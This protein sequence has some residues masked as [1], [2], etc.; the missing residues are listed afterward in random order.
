MTIYQLIVYGALGTI[1]SSIT[2]T[3]EYLQTFPVFLQKLLP[4]MPVF[5]LYLK[6]ILHLAI[7]SSALGGSYGIMFSNT[8]NLH[9]LAKNKHTFFSKFFTSLNQ[10]AIPFACVIF[11]GFMYL[12]YLFISGGDQMLLQPTAV[13]GTILAF[14]LSVIAL[15]LAK[16]KRANTK[17]NILIPIFGL[18]VCGL[19]AYQCVKTL[20]SGGISSILILFTVLLILG[21][22][23][24]FV[25]RKNNKKLAQL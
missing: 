18:F 19:M 8:W 5:A 21:Y 15:I 10:H 2:Q 13:L 16:L 4:N 3:P 6:A 12:V 11:I 1:L 7:A 25:M 20:I 9:T 23:M 24:Y 17:I 14:T 22:V